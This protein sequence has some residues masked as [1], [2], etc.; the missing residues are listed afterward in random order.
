MPSDY[1]ILAGIAVLSIGAGLA[2]LVQARKY[3]ARRHGQ[4]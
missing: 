3:R 4:G 2:L 1:V